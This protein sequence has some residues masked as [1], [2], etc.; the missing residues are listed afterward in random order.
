[1]VSDF[2][3][4]SAARYSVPLTP[5]KVA[6]FTLVMPRRAC[7]LLTTSGPSWNSAP[8]PVIVKPI[9]PVKPA[10]TVKARSSVAVLSDK[11]VALAGG[12]NAV[13]RGDHVGAGVAVPF[14]NRGADRAACRFADHFDIDKRR[15]CRTRV[16]V[17]FERRAADRR[18]RRRSRRSPHPSPLR[19]G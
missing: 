5:P 2:A 13:D 14:A 11:R 17:Q 19:A 16:E 3:R 12:L 8:P 18:A 10:S 7:W 4:R 9:E 6:V 1:M 15:R